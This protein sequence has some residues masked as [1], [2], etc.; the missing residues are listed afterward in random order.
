MRLKDLDEPRRFFAMFSHRWASPQFPC[1]AIAVITLLKAQMLG[2]M[3]EP[4]AR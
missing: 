1:L 3:P 2:A 4:S